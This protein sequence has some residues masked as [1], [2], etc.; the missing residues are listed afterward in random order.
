MRTAVMVAAREVREKSRLFLV[1][2]AFAL[3]PFAAT[4]LPGTRGQ[5]ADTIALMGRI[6]SATLGLGIAIAFG[7]STIVRELA[8]RRMSFYFT[9]PVSAAALWLGKAVA[10]VLVSMSCFAIIAIPAMLVSGRQYAIT[11]GQWFALGAHAIVVFFLVAHTL[12]TVVRSRSPLLALDFLFLIGTVTALYLIA[13]PLMLGGAIQLLGWVQLAIAAAIL[14]VLAV[15]PVWQLANGRTDI[16]RSHAALMRVLWP[17]IAVVLLIAAG[18]VAWVV[19]VSPN[20]VDVMTIEQPSNGARAIVTGTARNRF[21]Y[22]TAFLVDRATGSYTR[23]ASPPWYGTQFSQDGRVAIWLQ[24]VGTFKFQGLE[25]YTAKGSTGILL[26]PAA[27]VILSGDGTRVAIVNGSLVA[28]HDLATGKLLASAAGLD[29]R[30]RQQ[31]FFVTRDLV[32]VIENDYLLNAATPLRVFELDV[33]ARATRKTGEQIAATT[34]NAVSVS[35]DGSRMFIRGA[36]IVADGRTAQT[37]ATLNAPHATHSAMLY[38]GRVAMIVLENGAPHLRTFGSEGA[39][40]H[41][42]AFPNTRSLW[43]AGETEN[44][45]LLLA[46]FGR[47]M[48]VVDLGSGAIERKLEGVRGPL[49]RWWGEPRLTRFGAN[50]ELVG[51]KAGALV[52]WNT[53]GSVR[54]ILR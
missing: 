13:R 45:K 16:R 37:I 36:N 8:D 17:A 50:Q 25:L 46:A 11:N 34:R 52:A 32:R 38:D 30:A 29:G 42:V 24:P 5:S 53:S 35:G 20:D 33:R 31:A 6:L 54:P 4:L 48:Y 40:Q 41:D 19:N 10:A 15:A 51:T 27:Q 1:C 49:P 44:G 22:Q 2:V 18:F 43:I 3:L 14:A 47:T 39:P 7:G 26:S 9:K 21:D 28:V 12:S 23:I